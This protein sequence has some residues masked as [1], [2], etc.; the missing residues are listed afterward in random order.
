ML[1]LLL[2]LDLVKELRHEY[3]WRWRKVA[4]LIEEFVPERLHPGA[5]PHPHPAQVPLWKA[6]PII[7][8]PGCR[9]AS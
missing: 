3:D 2:S 8:P 9:S 7:I 1:R 4:G 5:H 6:S